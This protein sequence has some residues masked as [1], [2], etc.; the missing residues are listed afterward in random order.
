VSNA[1]LLMGE[2]RGGCCPPWLLL[3]LAVISGLL[4]FRLDAKLSL[5]EGLL[6]AILS[7]TAFFR[8]KT[9]WACSTY[10]AIYVGVS[11]FCFPLTPLEIFA[12]FC[13]GFPFGVLIDIIGRMVG[14]V[15]AFGIARLLLLY[16][17]ETCACVSGQAVLKGVGRATQEHGLRFLVLFNLAYVPA[18]I[19]SYGLGFVKEVPLMQF[20]IAIFIIEVPAATI[21]CF[22]GNLAAEQFAA[23]GLS[24]SNSTAMFNEL[25]GKTRNA[26]VK[27]VLLGLG[28]F[29]IAVVLWIVHSRVSE[30]L[31]RMKQEEEMEAD[32]LVPA[33]GSAKEPLSER[34][35]YGSLG[36]GAII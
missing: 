23:D 28:I 18:A 5:H 25:S 13:F 12:G 26:P 24:I 27:I 8:T 22:L 16:G 4:V 10:I 19:K 35:T 36:V 20:V 32:D 29:A 2:S 15:L 11:L 30:E 33:G 17:P 1:L 3:G 14:S 6:S 7:M 31:D 34:K 21:S 9:L